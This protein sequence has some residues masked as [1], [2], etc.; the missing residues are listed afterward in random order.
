MLEVTA[1]TVN[2]K[3]Y[4][5]TKAAVESLQKHY[6]GLPMIVHDNGSEDL[7]TAYI[8]HL[9]DQVPTVTSIMSKT[10]DGHGPALHRC[11]RACASVWAL[12]FDS[13]CELL[14]PGLIEMLL[15]RANGA[16]AVGWQRYVDRYTGVPIEWHLQ[17]QA[18]NIAQFVKYIHPCCALYHVPTYFTLRP[19]AHHGAP[20]LDNMLDA[21][22][23]GLTLVEAPVFDYVKHWV[24]GTRRM[25]DSEQGDWNPQPGQ[26]PKLWDANAVVPI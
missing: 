11:M 20:C 13:D 6:P 26:Q 8:S 5:L 17:S 18:A 1:I 24:G 23:M 4:H 16:Y 2:Y 14:K 10:N 9:P 22:K 3:T 19:F 25:F 15:E 21:E 7:S 12:L